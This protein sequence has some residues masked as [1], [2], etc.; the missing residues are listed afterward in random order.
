MRHLT[1]QQIELARAM[2]NQPQMYRD[3][4]GDSVRAW[5]SRQAESDIWE[6]RL[7]GPL[8]WLWLIPHTYREMG[9][10]LSFTAVTVAGLFLTI[11][12]SCFFWFNSPGTGEVIGRI[13]RVQQVGVLNK[14]WEAQ[15]IRGGLHEGTG[16]LGSTLSFTIENESQA[17]SLEK[18]VTLGTEVRLAYRTELICSKIRS[19]SGGYF[20]VD[21]VQILK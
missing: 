11:F 3:G 20:V 14:T 7:H 15:I 8:R 4:D 10:V 2:S 16:V 21:V 17:K 13:V 19:E 18:Y 9:F 1:E 5:N 12:L 6:A